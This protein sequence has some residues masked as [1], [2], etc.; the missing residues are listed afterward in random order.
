M[1]VCGGGGWANARTQKI[2]FRNGEDWI[3]YVWCVCVRAPRASVRLGEVN[4]YNRHGGCATRAVDEQLVRARWSAECQI[5]VAK[6]F[7]LERVYYVRGR[8]PVNALTEVVLF[9][10]CQAS[11][12]AKPPF[13]DEFVIRPRVRTGPCLGVAITIPVGKC[14]DRRFTDETAADRVPPCFG[15]LS[16]RYCVSTAPPLVDSRLW[17]NE[18]FPLFSFSVETNVWTPPIYRPRRQRTRFNPIY[19][20]EQMINTNIARAKCNAYIRIGITRGLLE[21]GK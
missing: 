20:R 4:F 15:R 16:P 21:R 17:I 12:H 1:C 7:S 10:S 2:I 14:H 5:S 19:T 8:A 3:V 11:V 6:R 13:S 18:K 9:R